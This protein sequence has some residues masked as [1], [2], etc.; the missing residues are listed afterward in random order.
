MFKP[1]KPPSFPH[2]VDELPMFGPPSSNRLCRAPPGE[3][4][5][6]VCHAVVAEFCSDPSVRECSS[7][8]GASAVARRFTI[9]IWVWINTYRYIFCGMNIHL[10]AILMW[11][12]GVQGFDTL[13]YEGFRRHGDF[14]VTVGFNTESWSSM[15]WIIWQYLY[16]GKAPYG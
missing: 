16:V 7:D 4:T 3:K 11:T 15:T 2:F 9:K 13:P 12:K 5:E 1:H 14:E 8:K 10:P 6:P